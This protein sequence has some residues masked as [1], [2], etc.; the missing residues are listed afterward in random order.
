MLSLSFPVDFSFY[1]PRH[2]NEQL[3][4]FLHRIAVGHAGDKIAGGAVR[5]LPLGYYPKLGRE[6]FRVLAVVIENAA[7]YAVDL[8][9]LALGLGV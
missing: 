2:G 9:L 8:A 7:Y 5:S 6:H 1:R 3:A 4:V